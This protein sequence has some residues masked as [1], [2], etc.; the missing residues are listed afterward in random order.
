MQHQWGLPS[1]PGTQSPEHLLLY[2]S[3]LGS[4]HNIILN[5]IILSIHF[6]LLPEMQKAHELKYAL[7]D[8]MR[9]CTLLTAFGGPVVL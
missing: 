4:A 1:T 7:V 8:L 9:D 2:H 5:A 3:A 6:Q